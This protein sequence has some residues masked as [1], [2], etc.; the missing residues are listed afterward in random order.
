MSV[1]SEMDGRRHPTRYRPSISSIK[2]LCPHICSGLVLCSPQANQN[3]QGPYLP[4]LLMAVQPTNLEDHFSVTVYS[5]K[6][7]HFGAPNT[8]TSRYSYQLHSVEGKEFRIADRACLAGGHF[9]Q[10]NNGVSVA[11]P[12]PL[13]LSP[14]GSTALGPWLLFQFVNTVHS[15]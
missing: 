1:C 6:Q 12:P 13:F 14:C 3:V 15:W 9:S 5:V 2:L 11:S 10:L 4:L 8:H 7:S